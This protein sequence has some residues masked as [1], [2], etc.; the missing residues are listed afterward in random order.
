MLG[1]EVFDTGTGPAGADPRPPPFG[2]PLRFSDVYAG[3][4]L[5]SLAG[6]VEGFQ[7]VEAVE[8]DAAA[9]ATCAENTRPLVGVIAGD[10]REWTPTAE[11]PIDVLVGGPP[12]Q[13]WSVRGKQ[14]GPCDPRADQWQQILRMVDASRPSVVVVE[15]VG[16]SPS[17]FRPGKFGVRGAGLLDKKFHDYWLAWWRAMNDLGYVG[18][19]W[20]LLAA[21]YGTPQLRARLFFVAWPRGAE[22]GEDL[23]APPMPTHGHPEWGAT[24]TAGGGARGVAVTKLLSGTMPVSLDPY[25]GGAGSAGRYVQSFQTPLRWAWT[26]SFDRLNDGCCGGFGAYSCVNLG[27]LGGACD[28]CFDRGNY[29]LA[30]NEN[31]EQAQLSPKALAGLL[32]HPERVGRSTQRPA[33]IGGGSPWADEVAPTMTAN[34]GRG[35]PYG[36]VVTAGSLVDFT[37][38][39]DFEFLRR[40][41]VREAAKLQ[42]VPAWFVFKGGSTSQYRQV[43]NGVPVNVGRAIFRHIRYALRRRTRQPEDM[44]CTGFWP[45]TRPR[46][47]PDYGVLRGEA[48]CPEP[49]WEVPP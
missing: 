42:D 13:P 26:S 43:G 44:E 20:S 27:N 25:A 17:T 23:I 38:P 14:R 30:P 49:W 22:W 5:L 9:A 15:N 45:A 7:L 36:L 39:E 4:G 32:K 11:I 41:T 40:L 1:G 31:I 33:D 6:E 21:D 16:S 19:I 34:L 10:A 28:T 35:A 3:A 37:K 2:R 29:E 47:C 12:C 46:M 8:I 18:V 48:D 24:F